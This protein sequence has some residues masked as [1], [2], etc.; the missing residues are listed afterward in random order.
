VFRTVSH[1]FLSEYV[2][3]VVK[4]AEDHQLP[5]DFVSETDYQEHM[6]TFT[7]P[8]Q[9][10]PISLKFPRVFSSCGVLLKLTASFV[11]KP[12]TP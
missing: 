3:L 1:S 2:K 9:A 11:R 10:Y 7:N 5:G 8:G 4:F 12:N 6:P